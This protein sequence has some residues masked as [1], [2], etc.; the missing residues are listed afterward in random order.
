MAPLKVK[1]IINKGREGV[2][3]DKLAIITKETL[4]FLNCVCTDLNIEENESRWIGTKF[5]SEHSLVFDCEREIEDNE[6]VRMGSELLEAIMSR[7]VSCSPVKVSNATKIQYYRIASQ[8]DVDESVDFGVYHPDNGRNPKMFTL[9]H[10]VARDIESETASEA[11][12]FGEIQGTIHSFYKGTR[13]KKFIISELVTGNY[14]DCY[15]QDRM[16]QEMVH[17][18]DDEEGIFFV[19]GEIIED[20]KAGVIKCIAIKDWSPAPIFNEQEFTSMI[21]TM[22]QLTGDETTEEYLNRIRNSAS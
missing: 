16:Y 14:V 17:L 1:V 5:S 3:L 19:S 13:R 15:F 11:I 6:K 18:L 2:P 10:R 20:M 7:N 8:I 12:Y 22:P 21:G 4:E 9:T